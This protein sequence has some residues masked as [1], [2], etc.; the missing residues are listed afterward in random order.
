[1]KNRQI[2]PSLLSADF[3]DL[4]N[5]LKIIEDAGSEWLHLDIMDG[6]FVPNITFGPPLIKSIR[7]HSKMF[8]DTHLM[9][10]NPDLYIEDF[11]KAGSDLITVHVETCNHLDRTL[12]LIK[13]IGC[14][15]GISFNPAT[16]INL[17]LID[18]IA[19]KLDLI[20]IMTVNPGFGGQKFIHSML[21]KIEK[22]HNYLEEKNYHHISIEVDGG[23]DTNTA[24]L[25]L[26]SGA[27]IL[28]AGSAV[29]GKENISNAFLDLKTHLTKI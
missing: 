7:P 11:A 21:G 13:N 1:M 28:V 14:K 25:V 24:P 29:F 22:L 8:F 12:S 9:I 15:S 18:Y 27:N 3:S 5:Q 19:D 20:L 6:H 17:D 16:P 10:E 4:R 2:A 26:S 23:I